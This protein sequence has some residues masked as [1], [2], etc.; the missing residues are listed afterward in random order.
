MG[1]SPGLG[2]ASAGQMYAGPPPIPSVAPIQYYLNLV[3]SEYRIATKMLTWLQVNLQ[4]YEDM[5]NCLVE[6]VAALDI[7]Q[8]Q[9]ECLDQLGLIIGANRT[10]GFQPSNSVSPTL[11]DTT[12]RLLL[13][14]TIA[15]NHWHGT[16]P[17]LLVIWRNLFPGGT[18]VFNDLQTMAVDIEVAGAFTS[19]IQDLILQGYIIPRPEGVL[20]TIT[21]AELP[22]LG[23]DRRDE[24]VAGL[25]EGHF[26]A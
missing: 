5:L 12:Y 11:D 4:L 17:E 1:S 24:W 25:D 3:T 23:F 14:A 13:K 26:I 15:K 19:I 22:M 6:M 8:A 20:Y 2:Q 18:I 9:G 21:L 16:L 10:V 7:D